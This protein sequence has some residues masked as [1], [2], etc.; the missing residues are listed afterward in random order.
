M[1]CTASVHWSRPK[2]VTPTHMS[3]QLTGEEGF[4][5]TRAVV[6]FVPGFRDARLVTGWASLYDLSPDWQPVIGEVA[7]NLFVDAGTSGHG[8][9]LAPALGAVVAELV[10]GHKVDQGLG[11][12]HPRRFE[13]GQFLEA[14]YDTARILG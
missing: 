13:A 10:M 8:V 5:L 4:S 14:G 2:Q 11:Q 1:T 7:E 9:K 12:F 6:S 3:N